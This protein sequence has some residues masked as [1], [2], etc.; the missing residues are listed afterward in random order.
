LVGLNF[1]LNTS[2]TKQISFYDWNIAHTKYLFSLPASL[3][4]RKRE[5]NVFMCFILIESAARTKFFFFLD[6]ERIAALVPS[7]CLVTK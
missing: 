3:A 5:F 7:H 1:S 2:L 6:W 4:Q